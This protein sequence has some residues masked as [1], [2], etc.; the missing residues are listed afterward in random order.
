MKRCSSALLFILAACSGGPPVAESLSGVIGGTPTGLLDPEA[1]EYVLLYGTSLTAINGFQ[2]CSGTLI[3]P[4]VVLTAGH[5]VEPLDPSASVAAHFFVRLPAWDLRQLA[6]VISSTQ[7]RH[8]N[9]R[10][11]HPLWQVGTELRSD[12]GLLYLDLPMEDAPVATLLEPGER[13]ALSFGRNFVAVGYGSHIRVSDSDFPRPLDPQM[14]RRSV[15]LWIAGVTITSFD[16]TSGDE[17]ICHGD[18]GGPAFASVTTTRGLERRQIGVVSASQGGLLGCN[19]PSRYARVD[20]LRAWIDQSM[21]A[22][23]KDGR[24]SPEGCQK[25]LTLLPGAAPSPTPNIDGEALPAISSAPQEV[26][27]GPAPPASGCRCVRG[28]SPSSGGALITELAG[29]LVALCALRRG[30][31]AQ[32]VHLRS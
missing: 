3:A 1:G 23:C 20:T 17:T 25:Q 22:A 12:L 29:L 31:R 2:F 15:E 9:A 13:G 16:A 4:D 30:A 27:D 14:V 10:D 5:C 18:S 19:S 11:Q 26:G 7:A 24:R 6:T 28:S 21:A 32:T 8:V